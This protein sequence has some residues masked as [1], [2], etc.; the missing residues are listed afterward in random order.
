MRPLIRGA[1]ANFLRK[2][3]SRDKRRIDWTLV[4]AWAGIVIALWIIVFV[5]ALR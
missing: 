2:P 1:I 4:L 5:L 3:G